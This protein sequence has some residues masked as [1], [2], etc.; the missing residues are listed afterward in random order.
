MNKYLSRLVAENPQL[1]EL[2]EEKQVEMNGHYIIHKVPKILGK[3]VIDNH[4]G[5]RRL[6]IRPYATRFENNGSGLYLPKESY[7]LRGCTLFC[8]HCGKA[9]EK[10]DFSSVNFD[11]KALIERIPLWSRVKDTVSAYLSRKEEKAVE[12]AE[13]A[14]TI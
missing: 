3:T 13:V 2:L 9:E 7:F 12:E 6:V 10:T 8:T 1:E 5:Y 11:T 4:C 14:S